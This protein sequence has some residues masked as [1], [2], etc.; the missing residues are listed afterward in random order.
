[1]TKDL[2]VVIFG[3]TGVTGQYVIREMAKVAADEDGLK[4]AVAGRNAEKLKE[5]LHST[6]GD[7]GREVTV[8]IADVTDA[9]SLNNMCKHAKIVLNTVGPYRFFGEPVVKAC[10][11][12]GTHHLDVSGEPQ[13]LESMQL[14]YY[15]EAKKAGVYVVGACGLDSIP[16]EIGVAFLKEKFNG[17]LDA[18]ETFLG[19]EA[20]PNGTHA[21]LGTWQSAI[22]GLA[23][24]AELKDL[25]QELY[26]KPY[27]KPLPKSQH[28]LPKRGTLFKSDVTSGWCIP[29]LGADKSVVMRSQMSNYALFNERGTQLATYMA[30]PNLFYAVMT[31]IMAGIFSFL[32]NYEFGRKL[33]ER[34]PGF[35]SFGLFREGGPTEE[36][37][38]DCKFSML[39]RGTGW[40]EKLTEPTDQH[41]TVP[42]KELTVCVKGPEGGYVSTS[43][44]LVHCAMVILKESDTMPKGGGVLTPGTAFGRSSLINRLKK[45]GVE[46]S[47]LEK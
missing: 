38:K 19:F 36:Q 33:L 9:E 26:K 2:D 1:M 46:F 5:C 11:E 37:I 3:A 20:G 7:T 6:L 23:H 29:F 27:L 12:N 16:C 45:S 22:Y 43:A 41:A 18:V 24:S 10:I 47:V 21:N 30:M 15:D 13:Y 34:F 28:R 39:L 32:A 44:F 17:D 4:W 40:A 14:K 8:I 31:L 35:F 42:D 25:R